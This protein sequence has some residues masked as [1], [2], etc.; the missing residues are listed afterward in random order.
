M[1]L[2]WQS[3]QERLFAFCVTTSHWSTQRVSVKSEGQSQSLQAKKRWSER[4]KTLR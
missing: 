4:A 1:G 2:F 3:G